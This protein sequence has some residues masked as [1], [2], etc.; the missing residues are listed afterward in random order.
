M[1]IYVGDFVLASVGTGAVVG[2]PGHD[3]RDFEFAQAVGLDIIRVVVGSDGDASSIT[4]AEQVQEKEGTM[5][6]S[7][8]LNGLDI[9]QATEKIED[10]LKEKGWGKRVVRYKLRDWVFSR[11]HYWGEPIPMI[12]CEKCKWTPVPEKDLPVRLPE[13]EHYEPTDTG[14]SPL[15]AMTDWVNVKCPKCGGPAKRETDTMPNWAGS[16]WYFL[17]YCDPRNDKAFADEKKLKYWLPVDLYNGGME[18]T[19]LHLLYSRFWNKFLYDCGLVPVSEPYARRVSHGMV[20]A[21]DGKKMSK[22]L[23][24]VVNPDDVVNNV[25]ADSLRLYE[26]FMGPF[27]DTIPWSTEGVK[28]VRRFLEKVFSLTPQPPLPKGEGERVPQH[29]GTSGVRALLHKTIKKVTE[30][31]IAMKFNTA[32]STMMIFVNEAQKQGITKDELEKFLIILAPFAP[33]IAEEL[34]A[35]L[36]NK[37]S[38]FKQFWPSYDVNLIKDEIIKLAVQVNGKLRDTI[39]VAA[40]ISDNEVKEKAL[41]SEK[42]KKWVD[43]KEIAKIIVVQNR[44]VNVVAK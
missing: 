40:D 29:C 12:F 4:K 22:S 10:Y 17:R 37:E 5:I 16:S 19:T 15:A 27:A 38:I 30:D 1:P 32:V 41:A 9:R 2:V 26:M 25:G 13:V 18:H 24:N 33:H 36:G 3:I 43:G 8:F 28:G 21:E 42:L 44:L 23:G 31:I 20:L 6:N 34:W 14:E 11:Q 35:Q 39:E 7:G